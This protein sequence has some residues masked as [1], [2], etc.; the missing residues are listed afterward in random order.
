MCAMVAP[1]LGNVQVTDVDDKP[2]LKTR[3]MERLKLGRT[4]CSRVR[5][6]F[7]FNQ[8][9]LTIVVAGRVPDI[10]DLASRQ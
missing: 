8:R 10:D 6:V 4:T 1:S 2:N 3:A 9:Q 7:S 5:L